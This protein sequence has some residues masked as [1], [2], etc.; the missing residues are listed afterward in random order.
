LNHKEIEACA[1][2]LNCIHGQCYSRYDDA[3]VRYLK[4]VKDERNKMLMQD[5]RY[6]SQRVNAF[7]TK[8]NDIRSF[9][10][11]EYIDTIQIQIR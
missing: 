10:L 8:I 3:Q 9:K 5:G 7:L 6:W 2:E 1:N 11:M 4:S